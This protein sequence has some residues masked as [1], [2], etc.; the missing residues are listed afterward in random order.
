MFFKTRM[1]R[2]LRGIL[3]AAQADGG[4]PVSALPSVLALERRALARGVTWRGLSAAQA[5]LLIVHDARL[6]LGGATTEATRLEQAAR[7]E[8]EARGLGPFWA[9]LE[10]EA[11]RIARREALHRQ[12]H[13]PRTLPCYV[14]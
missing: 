11:W 6:A 14:W 4:D 3:A 2:V 8:A 1:R 12:G 13:P 7:R 5:A 10:H 9:T